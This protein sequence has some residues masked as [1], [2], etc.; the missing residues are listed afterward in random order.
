MFVTHKFQLYSDSIKQLRDLVPPF[1][2]NGFGEF[3]FYRTYSR[4][5]QDGGQ[6]D[7]CDLVVRNTNG[8]FS[9]RKDWYIKNHIHWDEDFWQA[10]ALK[11]AISM[12]MMEWMPPGRG[13]W[14]MGSDFMYERGSMALYNCAFTNI[15]STNLDDDISW[16]MDSLMHGVGVGFGPEREPLKIYK[17]V[18]TY[19]FVIPDSRE[20]WCDSE[21]A[22]INAFI[23]PGQ[24]LP[25]MIYDKVREAGLPIKGFGGISS[26]PGPLKDLHERTIAEF[27]R[28][29]TRPEYDVVYLKTNLANHTGCCVVAGNVRRSAELGKGK[30]SDPTFKDLKDYS[31]YPERE[32]FGWMSN[33]SVELETEDDFMMLGEIAQRVIKNGEP[34]YIN[35]RNFPYGRIGKKMK[36][37]RMDMATGMNPCG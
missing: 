26:G 21:K 28:Y 16:L 29:M 6:E 36:N 12:F 20:G 10:Y 34:G 14:A 8:T 2:Y 35:L 13:L 3:I 31:K 30:M 33:N 17:P 11:F 9:I 7:W 25:R 23:R 37:L 24:K 19:D 15:T 27:E 32:A 5:K 4:V 22:L 18:G 1:G